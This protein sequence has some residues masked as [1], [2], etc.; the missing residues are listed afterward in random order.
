[1]ENNS[2][3]SEQP[4]TPTTAHLRKAE[5]Q[6]HHGVNVPS[7]EDDVEVQEAIMAS[8][9]PNCQ[10]PKPES[11]ASDDIAAI[12]N[13]YSDNHLSQDGEQLI[14]ELMQ[15]YSLELCKQMYNLVQPQQPTEPKVNF[16][17]CKQAANQ[18]KSYTEF[19]QDV[20]PPDGF[21]SLP[22]KK[23]ADSSKIKLGSP[24]GKTET[25]AEQAESK[26]KEKSGT[27]TPVTGVKSKKE[28]LLP[29]YLD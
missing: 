17:M 11:E 1:M 9:Q 14:D 4:M 28:S 20:K 12:V 16:E 24:W 25:K 19:Y 2:D 7:K 3:Q 5:K 6:P 21:K 18:L 8:L 23:E 22:P 29:K 26:P 13:N 15:R 10:H 27:E